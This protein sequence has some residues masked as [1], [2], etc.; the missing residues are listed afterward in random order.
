[1]SVS[2]YQTASL[3]TLAKLGVLFFSFSNILSAQ[4]TRL[5]FNRDVRPILSDK[6]Y[7]CHGP[8]ADNQES[9]F[10]LNS[11]EAAIAD[12]GGYAGIVPGNV[13]ASE[14]H[15]RI[16]EDVVEDELMPPQDSKL[17]LSVEQKRILDRWIAEGAEYDEHW[18]FKTI[19]R[20]E[21]PDLSAKNKS[22]ASNEI[23]HFIAAR[24]HEEGLEPSNLALKET[25]IR[26]VT[27]DLTGLPPT[28]NEVE[29]FL[30]DKSPDAWEK[31][32]DRLLASERYG[33]RMALVWLDAARYADSGG[34]QND[35]QRSQ[36]PWRD[37]VIEAYNSNM[38]FDQFTIEQ[39]AGDLL[40]NPSKNQRLATAFNRN[41]R[42]NNEGGIV[43]EEYLVEYVADRAETT[44]TVWLGLTVGCARC[45]DHKYDPIS[46]KDYYELFAFFHN[47]DENGKDG[48]IAPRPNMMVYTTGTEE[49]H[50]QLKK[51]IS[52]TENEIKN[53][54]KN[55]A[56]IF[57]A[58]IN[59]QK[60]GK[61]ELIDELAQF[62]EARLHFPLDSGNA[63]FTPNARNAALKGVFGGRGT[64]YPTLEKGTTFGSGFKFGTANYIRVN[65]PHKNDFDSQRPYSWLIQ[66]VTPNVFAGSEGPVLA[67]AEDG[68]QKGY[69][70]MLE[71]TGEKSNFR[72]SFQLMDNI[73]ENLG[74]EVVSGPVILPSA[75][76]RIGVSW[77]GSGKAHGVK[78]FID[79]QPAET[80]VVL[81]N[82]PK[83]VQTDNN[84]LLGA[85]A[86]TDAKDALRDATLLR[87]IID[88]VQVYEQE[89][90]EAQMVKLSTTDPKY[91]LLAASQKTVQSF[92]ETT[93][94]REDAEGQS[95]TKML[96]EQKTKL[97][98]FENKK[99]ASVSIM[100]E[101]DKPR[102]TYLLTRGA[103]DHPDKSQELSPS[104]LSALPP[105]GNSLPRN[106][107]GLA[108][109]LVDPKNPLTARVAINRYWQ[110]YF[111]TG[112]VKST[113]DFGSQGESP[114]HPELM[115]WLAS[116]FIESGWNV[117]EMQKRIVMSSTYRQSSFVTPELLEKDPDNRFLAR[118]PRFRLDGQALRDQAL[119]VSGFLA[120]KIGGPPVM[121]YQPAGLWDEVSAKGYKYIVG[122]G[123][124]LYRRSL[125][126]F[127]RR[128]VPPPSM[129]NFDTSA[130][131]ACSVRSSRTNTPLQALNL[132]N[133]PQFVEAARGLAE[134]MMMEGGASEKDQIAFG[135]R[136][137][138]AR[139]PEPE[140]L[141]ILTKGYE[142]YLTTYRSDPDKAEQLISVGVSK[143]DQSLNPAAL[144][145]MTTISNILLNLDEA[146]TKE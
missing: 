77:D 14:L 118:G 60:E 36:W 119:A 124:D 29:A 40:P 143:P 130:R 3:A 67:A 41:H 17:S 31:V 69:R 83:S 142:D 72:V 137:L 55:R 66:L 138:L 61:Q 135:Y 13:E 146:L 37:W 48:D 6:C 24:L 32:V 62:P 111:G 56:S 132:M 73:R 141:D 139:S 101:M 68:T 26:R 11:R 42:I 85:R 30:N 102:K 136:V 140:I 82:L 104:T 18:S 27:L 8:D 5:D 84:L 93:W 116:E 88:D 129:M 19:S 65:N 46:Q 126:T 7:R 127:W 54:S 100:E 107:L 108:K 2:V 25:Q 44:S 115:D 34:Y 76:V 23:D 50:L 87:G 64:N 43:P 74:I 39:L 16:W 92:L 35:A 86:Q 53:L 131:E 1:M 51:T 125:Y 10:R 105:L 28:P 59:E 22:W 4:D 110:M 20:P 33:E 121:P 12:L 38:P 58:W 75:P 52:N 98:N 70:L 99:V 21:I 47:L 45:H 95:L 133:D 15:F 106:R 91:L 145:A 49:E 112:L 57:N 144:A 122:K 80:K 113:E 90:T 117:K 79:G 63:T 81:D 97:E 94:I 123:D 89:L 103:Y 9:D 134:R 71:E 120:P 96:E 128:T 109:W 114:S 78:L